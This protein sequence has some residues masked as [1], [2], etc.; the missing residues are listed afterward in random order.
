M[1]I[2]FRPNVF[3]QAKVRPPSTG[4]KTTDESMAVIIQPYLKELMKIGKNYPKTIMYMP[5]VW[6]GW[7]HN[8]AQ[9]MCPAVT[10]TSTDESEYFPH[11]VAQY[12]APQ[13]QQV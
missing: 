3:L 4:N 13:T 12:H 1:F 10:S 9:S 6:C 2:H 11:A 5:L 7:A 8:L